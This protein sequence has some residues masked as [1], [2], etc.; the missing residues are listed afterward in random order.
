MVGSGRPL[1]WSIVSK[2]GESRPDHVAGQHGDLNLQKPAQGVFYGDPYAVTNDAWGIVQSQ[3]IKPVTVNGVDMYVV[4]RPNSGY[5]G[6][7]SGQRQ[8]LDTMTI[9]TLPGTNRVITAYP[10]NGLPTPTALK[11]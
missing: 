2:T 3:G 10:G 8:N 1:D 5:G 7:Y 9:I 6:G 4:P 11:P